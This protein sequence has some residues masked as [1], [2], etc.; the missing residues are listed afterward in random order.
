MYRKRQRF[1]AFAGN[2][3]RVAG[4]DNGNAGNDNG[5]AENDSVLATISLGKMES[6]P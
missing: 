1:P 3:K 5:N 4:N 2:D 6:A